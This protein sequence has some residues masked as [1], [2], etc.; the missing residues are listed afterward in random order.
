M[1]MPA[2]TDLYLT[3]P[4]EQLKAALAADASTTEKLVAYAKANRDNIP[5]EALAALGLA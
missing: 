2:S 1:A 4:P 3:M 5:R